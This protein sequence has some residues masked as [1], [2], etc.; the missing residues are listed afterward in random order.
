[1]A[2][3]SL[4]HGVVWVKSF[5]VTAAESCRQIQKI[6]KKAHTF[7]HALSIS[8]SSARPCSAPSIKPCH[9]PHAKHPIL[10]ETS[11]DNICSVNMSSAWLH[12][13]RPGVIVSSYPTS[14]FWRR[15]HQASQIVPGRGLDARQQMA[16]AVRPVSRSHGP[17]CGRPKA[18]TGPTSATRV[19]ST[20]SRSP[21]QLH[22]TRK[23]HLQKPRSTLDLR[24]NETC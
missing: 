23:M 6:D 14:G 1:V 4:Q 17:S 22:V 11:Q 10:I 19:L 21:Y 2:V 20:P 16:H 3:R 24:T 18:Q 15:Q 8:L 12:S 7:A 13:C 5:N 9:A